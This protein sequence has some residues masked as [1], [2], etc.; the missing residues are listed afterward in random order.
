MKLTPDLSL[1][2]FTLSFQAKELTELAGQNPNVHVLTLDVTNFDEFESFAE[3]V[4]LG[5][6]SNATAFERTTFNL[7]SLCLMHLLSLHR[8]KQ[9]VVMLS[10]DLKE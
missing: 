8:H 7:T 5:H 4:I 9:S 2:Y 10:I 1:I 6:L 3:K